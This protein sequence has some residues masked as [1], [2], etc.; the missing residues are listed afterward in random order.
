VAA[1]NRA[2]SHGKEQ[3][4]AVRRLEDV[5]AATDE[6]PG[7]KVRLLKRIED[8]E[9]KTLDVAP[10]SSTPFHAHPHAHEGVIV[11]GSGALRFTNESQ[12]LEPGCV[13]SVDPQEPHAIESHGAETLRLICLDC[14]IE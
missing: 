12:L 7:V 3:V 14:F 6:S 5:P 10:G 8:I 9:L 2:E 13:F 4:M 1:H 11:A